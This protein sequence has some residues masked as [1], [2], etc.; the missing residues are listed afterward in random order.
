MAKGLKEIMSTTEK[1]EIVVLIEIEKNV[2]KKGK[3]GLI[4]IQ[5][6]P[7]LVKKI[8]NLRHRFRR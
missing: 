1:G 7:L 6:K 2:Y 8:N 3:N 5:S 4:R